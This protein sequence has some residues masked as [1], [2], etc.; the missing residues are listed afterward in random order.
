MIYLDSAAIVKLIRPEK[1]TGALHA[2][3][4][5]EHDKTLVASSLVTTEVPRALLRADPGDLKADVRHSPTRSSGRDR[6]GDERGINRLVSASGPLRR[7]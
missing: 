5:G 1:E 6:V 2:W 4:A 7:W 3:L